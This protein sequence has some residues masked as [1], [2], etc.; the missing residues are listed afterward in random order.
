[1]EQPNDTPLGLDLIQ[2]HTKRPVLI[3]E[4]PQ[5]QAAL[6]AADCIGAYA[7]EWAP[8]LYVLLNRDVILLPRTERWAERVWWQLAGTTHRQ[9]IIR[10]PCPV[11]ELVAEG[12]QR[13]AE[14]VTAAWLRKSDDPMHA[15]TPKAQR[16]PEAVQ[17]A[18]E[19][20]RNVVDMKGQP[21]EPKPAP[22]PSWVDAIIATA[23]GQPKPLLANALLYL[24]NRDEWRGVL[25]YD[26]FTAAVTVRRDAPQGTKKD[27][28][29]TD[30]DDG[31]TA[32]WLQ[33]EGVHVPTR[34]AAEAVN[35]VARE[36]PFNPLTDW[37]DA[38]EWD[39]Q[40]RL[41]DWLIEHC[42]ADPIP[43]VRAWS[44]KWMIGAVAR[45][46][47][48]GC[49]H[50]A[51]LVIEGP[52]DVGKSTVLRILGSPYYTD[53]MP[54][55]HGREAAMLTRG[56]WIVEIAE[57]AAMAKSEVEMVKA[58]ISRV[59]DNYRP[60]YGLRPIKATRTVA[61]AGTVNPGGSG[62]LRDETGNTRFWP[63]EVTRADLE[64]IRAIREQ[65]WAE[66]VHRYRAGEKWWIT[67]DWL[68]ADAAEQQNQRR[69]V[70]AWEEEIEHFIHHKP[71]R[72]GVG[73]PA[74]SIQWEKRDQPLAEVTIAEIMSECFGLV[75]S[76]WPQADQKRV[77]RALRALGFMK[78]QRREGVTRKKCF[79]L[80]F[81]R[82]TPID[83]RLS[84]NEDDGYVPDRL[85]E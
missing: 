27:R 52:Q 48:P 53:D 38:L 6:V 24:R 10:P 3:A 65:L 75:N 39:R 55:M 28:P 72:T 82:L 45:A 57:L 22:E 12:K 16:Q 17:E 84:P 64:T 79:R 42:G 37:L 18:A 69:D 44:S 30:D 2:T 25:A 67:D 33:H 43:I 63:V 77:G 1:M 32:A 71:W 74:E 68:I 54:A 85:L 78:G 5:D 13:I 7:A 66:A 29:W 41:D 51:V 4:T 59:E 36:N 61:F 49:M 31:R 9:R 73:T 76:K 26:E 47:Q 70:D 14:L 81:G 62:Y 11:P 56:T 80:P 19:P 60:P 46:Y 34:V 35:I 83:G 58:F 8:N 40:P 23:K 21:I 50:R 15:P 20:P